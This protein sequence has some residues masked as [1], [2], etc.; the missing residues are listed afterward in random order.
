MRPL[1]GPSAAASSGA[2]HQMVTISDGRYSEVCSPPCLA[3][4]NRS[5]GT[6]T[7][8]H[9][10]DRITFTVT[11]TDLATAF[12]HSKTQRSVRVSWASNS[13]RTDSIVTA[14]QKIALRPDSASSGTQEF[15]CSV[16]SRS[17]C[18]EDHHGSRSQTPRAWRECCG[19]RIKANSGG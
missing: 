10:R 5:E 1:G 16:G 8:D 4:V 9:A 12:D 2:H 17:S 7:L 11:R 19:K 18:R 15:G 6:Y 13:I 14:N 3:I